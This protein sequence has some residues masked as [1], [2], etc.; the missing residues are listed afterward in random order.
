MTSPPLKITD[1]IQPERLS[2]FMNRA[3]EFHAVSLSVLDSNG[4]PLPAPVE[5]VP[6]P[7]ELHGDPE[8]IRAFVSVHRKGRFKGLPI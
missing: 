1:L 6:R 3:T 7:A 2:K 5:R 8:V 4:H